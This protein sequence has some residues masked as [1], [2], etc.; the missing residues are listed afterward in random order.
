MNPAELDD[1]RIEALRAEASMRL[2][3]GAPLVAAELLAQAQDHAEAAA[4]FEEHGDAIRAAQLQA[5]MGQNERAADLLVK[6]LA[7]SSGRRLSAAATTRACR[8]AGELYAHAGRVERAVQVL[9]WGGELEYA[10]QLLADTGRLVEAQRLFV[11]VGN[12]LAAAETARKAGDLASHHRFLGKRDEQSG[13]LGEAAVHFQEAGEHYEAVRL[14]ELAGDWTKAAEAAARG[15]LWDAAS[16]LYER[17]GDLERAANC[18]RSA[19]RPHD[20]E[21]LLGRRRRSTEDGVLTEAVALLAEARAGRDELYEEAVTRLRQVPSESSEHLAARTMLGEVLT[22]RGLTQEALTV[23]QELF[24][25]VAPTPAHVPAVYQYGVLLEREGYFAGARNAFRT[26]AAFEPGYRDVTRRLARLRETDRSTFGSS[27]GRGSSIVARPMVF[28]GPDPGRSPEET[29]P[30]MPTMPGT[31]SDLGPSALTSDLFLAPPSAS[32]PQ[33]GL[34]KDATQPVAP[35]RRPSTPRR[36]E[37]IGTVLRSRFLLERR[38]GRGAQAKVYLARDQVLDR[39]VAI[40]VLDEGLQPD[41]AALGRFLREA[42]LAARVRH[43]NC[44]SIYDFGQ[45]AGLTFIAMEF[46]EG[47]TLRKWL[48]KGP[49]EVRLALRIARD[50]AAALAAVHEAGILHRDVKPTNVLVDAEAEVRLTDFGVARF[51]NDDSGQGMMVGTMRYMAPEQARGK[52]TDARADVFSFGVLLHEMLVGKAPFGSTL[53]ALIERVKRPPPELP[54][55]PRY[56]PQLRAFLRR[57]LSL[58]PEGR[59]GSML[60]LIQSIDRLRS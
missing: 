32:G 58:E 20:A 1:E 33:A 53:D 47:R 52:E 50:V 4:L 42:R 29:G 45:E 11:E 37:L 17:M 3:E 7:G 10:A 57:C 24:L 21:R 46:F 19:G 55:D 12:L 51:V 48:E 38:V 26:V 36:D 30:R 56:S 14:F 25:G 9:R 8:K 41:D 39:A 6:A 23:L 54:D 49:L 44:I 2:R 5:E 27:P 43:P 34:R 60:E 15:Q 59:P 28:T 35:P 16:R 31:T 18:L 40:K 13:R 22:E